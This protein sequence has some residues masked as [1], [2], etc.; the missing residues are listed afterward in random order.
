MQDSSDEVY[1][2]DHINAPASPGTGEPVAGD[3][4]RFKR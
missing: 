1:V 3:E 4:A 2:A